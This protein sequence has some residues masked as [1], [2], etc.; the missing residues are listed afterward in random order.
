MSC[1]SPH[2]SLTRPPQTISELIRA[3]TELTRVKTSY[4]TLDALAKLDS[5]YLASITPAPAPVA[6][7]PK[8][9]AIKAAV[10]KLTK[11]EEM[12][13]DRWTRLVDMVRRGK[14]E[15]LAAFLDKYGPELEPI[16]EMERGVWGTLPDWMEEARTTPTLL[17]VAS[18]ADQP[19]MVRWLL[20]EKR[21][22]PT[23][24][25]SASP[26]LPHLP[27][28]ST[29]AID[30]I[31]PA[32]A[33]L[34]SSSTRPIL[35]PYELAPSRAT[36][37]VFRFLTATHPDWWDWTGSGAT[38]ARVP[39]GLTEEKE[40]EREQKDRERRAKLRDKLKIR[41]KEREA[42]E[43]IEREKAEKEEKLRADKEVAELLRTGK[44]KIVPT[45]PQRLGGGPPRAIV[46]RDAEAA[47]LSELQQARVARE[48][49]ARAAEARMAR[50]S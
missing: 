48:M 14:T 16:K 45:G 25:A 41:D 30:T 5:E 27:D 33:T 24:A 12:E 7:T 26:L 42:K 43:T 39:S 2:S 11:E 15:A 13:R 8:P 31:P 46:A 17:H 36:R 6:P 22:D 1:I 50:P 23:V 49:R 3:F 19:E 29:L 28:P 40:E 4:L 34:T 21:A 20:V 18:I 32:P 44:N 38:G 37:N 10:V 35:T 47:G 9:L